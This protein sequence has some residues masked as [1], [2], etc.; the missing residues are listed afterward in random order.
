MA[1]DDEPELPYNCPLCG[2]GNRPLKNMGREIKYFPTVLYECIRCS[3][4]VFIRD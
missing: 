1:E 4:M 3:Y 2:A